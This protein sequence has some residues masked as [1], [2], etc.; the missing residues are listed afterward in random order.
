MVGLVKEIVTIC[1]IF[2]EGGKE[3]SPQPAGCLQVVCGG[4]KQDTAGGVLP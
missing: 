1:Y 2:R 4:V 3:L